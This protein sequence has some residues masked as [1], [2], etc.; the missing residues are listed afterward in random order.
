MSKLLDQDIE[1]VQKRPVY[2]T[3]IKSKY[4]SQ[5]APLTFFP[6]LQPCQQLSIPTLINPSYSPDDHHLIMTTSFVKEAHDIEVLKT[7]LKPHLGN[8]VNYW[9]L[10]HQHHIEYALPSTAVFPNLPNNMSICGDWIG[11]GSIDSAI[12]T[13]IDIAKNLI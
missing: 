11:Y 1:A 9:E 3:F 2:T 7:S 6:G 13:G 10:I 4:V 5:L 12:K 8:Q